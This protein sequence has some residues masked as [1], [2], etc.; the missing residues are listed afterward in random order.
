MSEVLSNLETS[1]VD[2]GEGMKDVA[3]IFKDRSMKVDSKLA[4]LSVATHN[5]KVSLGV[6]VPLDARFEAPTLWGTTGFIADELIKVDD[7]AA[8]LNESFL[9]VKESVATILVSLEEAKANSN[10]E[11]IVQDVKVVLDRVRTLGPEVGNLQT[12][13]ASLV[14]TVSKLSS[15]RPCKM[16]GY[17]TQR[18][19]ADDLLSMLAGNSLDLDDSSPG[20]PV[21]TTGEPHDHPCCDRL[22]AIIDQILLDVETLKA[23]VEDATVKFGGLGLKNFAECAA[24]VRT[25]F[26]GLRYDLI[27]DPHITFD[28]IFG[29]EHTD[30]TAYLKMLETRLKLSIET[31]AEASA[32]H[33]L[34]LPRPRLFHVGRLA[35]HVEPNK[36]RLNKLIAHKCWKSGDVG[37]HNHI[38]KQMNM[39][40]T[41]MM[42]D[43]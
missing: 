5:F 18:G 29:N 9:P 16:T 25:S 1:V 11:K 43:G 12:T 10:S 20:I 40:H 8:A 30:S 27:I 24:W 15:D 28:H 23:S 17:G 36:P 31:G 13:L 4:M 22:Q 26:P 3:E 38:V 6:G 14:N 32:L 42:T 2:M 35:I 21:V 33:S 34:Q 39:L 7:D 19:Q 37:V 41:S